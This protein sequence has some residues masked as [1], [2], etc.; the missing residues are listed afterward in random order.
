MRTA[1]DNEPL[2]TI[3]L[4]MHGL[5]VILHEIFH[6][7]APQSDSNAFSLGFLPSCRIEAPE[8]LLGVRLAI[9]KFI[10]HSPVE[11]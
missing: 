9:A 4:Q 5:C 6:T 8:R 11:P 1:V 10:R 7:V 3:P 2:S